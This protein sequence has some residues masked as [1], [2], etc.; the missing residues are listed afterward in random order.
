MS[1]RA[2]VVTISIIMMIMLA[3]LP[4][5]AVIAR[6]PARLENPLTAAI[7]AAPGQV[8][9]HNFH[10]HLN[11]SANVPAYDT[12]AQGQAL[13][14]FSEDAQ[15]LYYKISAANI[16]DV[17]ASH[18]HCAPA[19][20]N[21]P[22]GV[23]LLLLSEPVSNPDGVLVEGTVSQPDPGNQCGWTSL[24]DVEDAIRAGDAYVNLHTTAH[25]SGE[26]RGQIR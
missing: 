18:I 9:T 10:A 12:S 24:A 11:G 23:T 14:K 22:V 4:A 19:G 7:Q 21:G 2:R 3:L 17:F 13:F 15:T 8:G 26:I 25:H 6:S 5:S 20:A 16:E 1:T